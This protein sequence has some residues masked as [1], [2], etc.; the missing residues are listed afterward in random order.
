[1]GILAGVAGFRAWTVEREI[2]L[3]PEKRLRS[4]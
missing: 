3:S 4:G 2:F 1:M